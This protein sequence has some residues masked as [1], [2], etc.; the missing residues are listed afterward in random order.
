MDDAIK[1]L[2]EAQ[3]EIKVKELSAWRKVRWHGGRLHYES[4]IIENEIEAYPVD[5]KLFYLESL[6]TREFSIQDNL[7]DSAPDITEQ[8]KNWLRKSILKLKFSQKHEASKDNTDKLKI[9]NPKMKIFISHS[10]KNKFYGD[11]LVDLL[12]NVGIKE[13]E[14]VFTSNIAYGIPISKNIFHWLKSQIEEKPFV[15]YLLSEEY[16]Q[17]VACLNEMGAAWIVENK[18]A[19]IFTPNFSLS[20]KEFQN[21]ALDPREIGFFITDE[22]RVYA[23]LEMLSQDFEVTKSTVLISQSVRKFLSEVSNHK[24]VNETRVERS[25]VKKEEVNSV[26]RPVIK[27]PTAAPTKRQVSITKGDSFS[28]F[29]NAIEEKKIT[30]EEILM[31]HYII[32]TGRFK[33]KTGWQEKQEVDNIVQWEEINE[34]EGKLSKNYATVLSKFEMRDL[35]EVSDVTNFKNPKEMKLKDEIYSHL[36]DMPES[37]M[38]AITECVER[39]HFDYS[40]TPEAKDDLPF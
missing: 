4:T 1:T 37:I 5:G 26:N 13:N 16:Y 3:V 39:N 22:E 28:K 9:E 35:T 10:S 7:P 17:S 33:L 8:L 36:N 6:L 31:L 23:F 14:I 15:I 30:D 12:R 25:E 24:T 11:K 38:N 21:G 29:T 2:I 20:S 18:H 34:I 32:T 40:K 19:A 27:A